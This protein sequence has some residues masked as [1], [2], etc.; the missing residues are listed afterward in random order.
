[1]PHKALK[2]L[3]AFKAEAEERTF[4]K[5]HDATDYVD[6]SKAQRATFTN[7]KPSTHS[8]ALRRPARILEGIKN[9]A[10]ERDFPY[11]AAPLDV[12]VSLSQ[13]LKRLMV[14]KTLS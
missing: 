14:D 7:L 6:L 4:W 2:A 10:N 13:K 8:I 5:K 11:E 9:A 1:M 3:P 12:E